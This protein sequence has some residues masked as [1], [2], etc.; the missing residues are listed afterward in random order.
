M[1]IKT[2]NEIIRILEEERDK[3]TRMDSE[4]VLKETLGEPRKQRLVL[5]VGH[6]RAKDK[7]AVGFDGTTTEWTYNRTLAHF[8]TLYLD[9][10][11]D[12][13][14][15]DTYKGNSYKEAMLNL[16]LT[17]DPLDPLLVVEL[18]FNSFSDPKANGYEALYWHSSKRGKQAAEAFVQAMYNAFPSHTNRGA[19]AIQGNSARGS[20]FLRT[21]KAPC[22]IL[23]PFFGSNPEEWQRFNAEPTGKQQLGK[24]VAL[25]IN[26]CFSEWGN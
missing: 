22:V 3:A 20:R 14:I 18:H 9:D 2:I 10:N 12:V 6:S 16:K 17:V 7:G 5:A 13:T 21:L 24:A 26:K 19:K 25:S 11:I 8:I 4:G 23:E 15:I 1:D